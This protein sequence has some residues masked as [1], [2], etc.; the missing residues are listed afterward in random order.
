[1]CGHAPFRGGGGLA[2]QQ[3]EVLP[4]CLHRGVAAVVARQWRWR[5][6]GRDVQGFGWRPTPGLGVGP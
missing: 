1:M 3:Q 6:G 4:V 2:A 5:P